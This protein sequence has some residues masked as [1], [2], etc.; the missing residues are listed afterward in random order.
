M[1]L[2]NS[3]KNE[4]E[5]FNLIAVGN[6]SSSDLNIFSLKADSIYSIFFV[7]NLTIIEHDFQHIALLSE[8]SVR[9]LFA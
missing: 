9:G 5:I 2:L 1:I 3:L 8:L 7:I 4:N 6:K